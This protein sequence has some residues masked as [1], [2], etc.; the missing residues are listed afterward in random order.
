MENFNTV[1]VMIIAVLKDVLMIP[2]T[3]IA[4]QNAPTAMDVKHAGANKTRIFA[5]H[6]Y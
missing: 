1:F 3:H 6:T 4:I 2:R 5:R